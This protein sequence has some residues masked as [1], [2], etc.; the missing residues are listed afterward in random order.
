MVL[1]EIDGEGELCAGVRNVQWKGR[2]VRSA[3]V[4]QTGWRD[5]AASGLARAARVDV[6]N[7]QSL[8]DDFGIAYEVGRVV[9]VQQRVRAERDGITQCQVTMAL[10]GCCGGHC[11]RSEQRECADKNG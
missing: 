7:V 3:N 5:E 2:A 4:V 9:C 8:R 1:Q 6:F 10:A 11:R